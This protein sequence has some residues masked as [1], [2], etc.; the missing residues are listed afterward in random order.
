V[1][2]DAALWFY[3]QENL[4]ALEAAGA[5]LAP[6]SLLDA[7]PWP[8]LDGLYLGGGLPELHAPALEANA[9]RRRQVARLAREGLPIYAECGGFM[10]LAERLELEG[11]SY[12]MAGVFPYAVRFYP[13]P[14]GLGYVQA[15]VAAAGP[16]FA[17]GRRLRGH[18]FHFSG[19]VEPLGAPVT[20]EG[21]L[22]RLGKGKGMWMDE[23]GI[24]YDGLLT[25]RTFAAYTHIYAPAV[26]EWAVNFVGLCR[27]YAAGRGLQ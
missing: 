8:E 26:P 11:G 10:Y 2:R 16:Y 18:E 17:A 20:A 12:A 13:R 23:A 21:F 1:V 15:E 24:G 3:Y 22:L 14:R 4:D 27:E 19:L 6:L 7:A 25:R 5:R 9:D